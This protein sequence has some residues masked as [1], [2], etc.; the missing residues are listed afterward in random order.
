[1]TE[2]EIAKKVWD[3]IDD[4]IADRQKW[5]EEAR[6]IEDKVQYEAEM[7]G[8]CVVEAR[9]KKILPR[10][11]RKVKKTVKRWTIALWKEDEGE[12]HSYGAYRTKSE[13]EKWLFGEEKEGTVV[14]YELSVEVEE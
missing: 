4:V 6:T 12:I 8:V 11:K 14:E 13:A 10:P 2:K 9:I 1:M 3:I 5:K 7:L